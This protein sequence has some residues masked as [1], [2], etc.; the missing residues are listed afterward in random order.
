[1]HSLGGRQLLTART[2]SAPVRVG[3]HWANEG[4]SLGLDGVT[5]VKSHSGDAVVTGYDFSDDECT[6][7][8]GDSERGT[9]S[10]SDQ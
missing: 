8:V 10:E 3:R 1:L 6:N 7:G 4:V 2:E 5:T 9:R